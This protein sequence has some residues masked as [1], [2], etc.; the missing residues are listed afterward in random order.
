MS[1][2]I[3]ESAIK[4]IE[5]LRTTKDQPGLCL[6]ITV[7]G[8]GCSGF[9]YIMELTESAKSKDLTFADCIVTDD[10]SLPFLEGAT[11]KFKDD[12]IGSEFIIDN[13]NAQS[14]CGC[15]SSFSV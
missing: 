6:R 10:I 13:P 3:D 11:I 1:L 12:L 8:G 4:R 15:G 7:E 5:H 2:N 14:G 9:Q